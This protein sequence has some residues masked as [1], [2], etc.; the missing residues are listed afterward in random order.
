MFCSLVILDDVTIAIRQELVS[1]GV[2]VAGCCSSVKAEY[3][4]TG[5]EVQSGR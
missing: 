3:E 4:A 1:F 5:R 2:F